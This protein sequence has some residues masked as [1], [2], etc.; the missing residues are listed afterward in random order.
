MLWQHG[1]TV[2]QYARLITDEETT[3][4]RVRDEAYTS[5]LLHDI[6][7]LIL[8]SKLPKEFMSALEYAAERKVSLFE[9]EK[10][11]LG[12]THSE[13]GAY[14]LDLWGLPDEVIKAISHH[15][16]PSGY[17]DEMYTFEKDRDFAPL[18][19]VHAANYFAEE[20]ESADSEIGKAELDMVYLESLGLES[21]VSDWWD[22]CKE[23][24]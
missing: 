20:A 24:S 12:V 2:G 23:H 19:A 3:D 14:L 16:F 13:I 9:A 21:H 17:A 1:L 18:T 7:L 10:E 5:G 11:V 6:G 15:V 8:A 22:L 4:S